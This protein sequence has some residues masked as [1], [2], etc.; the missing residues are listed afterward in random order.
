[1]ASFVP[2]KGLGERDLVA[3]KIHPGEEGNHY[4][5]APD[6]VQAVARGLG[7]PQ[8]GLFFT[9]TTVLYR[10][11]RMVA[12]D[13]V[14]LAHEHGFGPPAT[15]PF[16]VADGLRGTD[17]VL[18]DLPPGSS[19]KQARMARL[20]SQADAMVVVSHFKGHLL[21]GFGGAIKNLGMGCASRGGKLYQHSTVTPQVSQERC[22]ACGICAEHC[23]E[24]AID[25]DDVAVIDQ[26]RC[27]GCGECL[28]RCPTGAM[29]V[30]WNQRTD[31]FVRRVAEYAWAATRLVP[32]VLFVNFV[33]DVS[34]DCDCMSDAGEPLFEDVG[35]LASTDP[36]ALDQACLDL[37][38]KAKV[39]D[40]ARLDQGTSEQAD[41]FTKLRPRTHGPDQLAWAER[42]GLGSRAYRLLGIG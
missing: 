38:S 20:L 17:E 23:P 1:M 25:V 3:V 5:V 4:Y 11:R 37:V 16:I 12:P 39:L 27:V 41:P 42:L 33:V 40:P 6:L 19:A 35:V 32:V 14:R 2:L 10:G 13:Y 8:T 9:D 7:L 30:A 24:D 34:P 15:A 36:V 21:A 28:Q 29:S 26:E 18:V 22:I 31:E